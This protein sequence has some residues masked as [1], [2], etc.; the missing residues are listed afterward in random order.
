MDAEVTDDYIGYDE[1]ENYDDRV[2]A[3]V[4]YYNV[5]RFAE[6]PPVFMK[7]VMVQ[8]TEEECAGTAVLYFPEKSFKEL[9][10]PE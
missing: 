10:K 3:S 7:T 4:Q 9:T 6:N 5:P 8:L 1:R 2:D